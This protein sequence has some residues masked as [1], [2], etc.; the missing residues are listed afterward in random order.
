M[1]D[2]T[3]IQCPQC[4]A[5]GKKEILGRVTPT[6]DMLVL[7]FHHGTT[8]LRATNYQLVC[9]CGYTWDISGTVVRELLPIYN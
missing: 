5:E 1:N 3:L 2:G 9:G 6:G 7:R 8:I 4:L